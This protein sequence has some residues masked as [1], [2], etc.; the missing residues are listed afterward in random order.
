[1]PLQFRITSGQ[2]GGYAPAVEPPDGQRAEAVI[3][4]R[5]YDADALV[6]RPPSPGAKVMIPP[7]CNR[8]RPRE[9]DRQ[10]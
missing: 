6:T 8:K 9:Y 2:D 4:D 5:G 1:M 7:K 3:V 10:L